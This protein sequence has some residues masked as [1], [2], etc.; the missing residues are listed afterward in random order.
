[1]EGD[2]EVLVQAAQLAEHPGVA[3]LQQAAEKLRL[4]DGAGLHAEVIPPPQDVHA[5][6]HQLPGK[7]QGVLHGV[8][9]QVF[10]KIKVGGQVQ[11]EVLQPAQVP[12]PLQHG[13]GHRPD[14]PVLLAVPLDQAAVLLQSDFGDL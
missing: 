6:L 7:R 4:H 9:Q 11:Q 1:M 5:H 12:G 3:A 14:D 8:V 10:H 13:A 2:L